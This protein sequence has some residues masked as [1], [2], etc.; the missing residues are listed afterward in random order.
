MVIDLQ[1]KDSGSGHPKEEETDQEKGLNLQ[2][3]VQ[4]ADHRALQGHRVDVHISLFR[5]QAIRK[6][7]QSK[8]LDSYIFLYRLVGLSLNF[9][10]LNSQMGYIKDF[11]ID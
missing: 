7:S 6:S 11:S 8:T 2:V 9:I 10:I 4:G 3:E 1:R 5:P